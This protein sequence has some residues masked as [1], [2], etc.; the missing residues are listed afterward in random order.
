MIAAWLA[1]VVCATPP[2]LAAMPLAPKNMPVETVQIL[3]LILVSELESTGKF[4]VIRPADIDAMIG[5]ERMKDA[6]GCDNVT[7]AT[8][9]ASA[10]GVELLMTGTVGKLGDEIVVE[11]TLIDAAHEQVRHRGQATAP[12]DERSYRDAIKRAVAAVLELPAPVAAVV[13]APP[14]PE[15]QLSPTTL[16]FDTG[17]GGRKFMVRVVTSDGQ[18][19]ECA[20]EEQ[21]PCTMTAL[22]I[23]NARLHATAAQLGP[24]DR[25]L[26]LGDKKE[27][28][29][30][31]LRK[32]PSIGSITFWTYG[33]TMLA[34]GAALIS[35]GAGTKQHGFYYSG[36]P[37][38]AAGGLL[39][40][41]GFTFDGQSDVG[42]EPPTRRRQDLVVAVL[43]AGFGRSC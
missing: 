21:S 29:V 28:T 34:V 19:H 5:L 38:A 36:I 13:A 26:V 32:Y 15:I 33:G 31:T 24:L 16:R 8:E 30:N 10:L 23:G 43:A 42:D 25:S 3:D 18:Q 40:G 22:A 27:T 1:L 4:A 41:L 6:A 7:C 20:V 14:H 11:L 35:V 9:L 17:D 37:V 39:L 2:Q 12:A